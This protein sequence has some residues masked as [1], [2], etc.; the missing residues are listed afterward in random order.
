MTD[1]QFFVHSHLLQIGV[2]IE[3]NRSL[4]RV[5]RQQLLTS[6]IYTGNFQ[7]QDFDHLILVTGRLPDKF[8]YEDLRARISELEDVGI[9]SLQRIGD[10]LVPSSIADAVYR[11]HRLAREADTLVSTHAPRELP[12]STFED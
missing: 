6:C 1:E 11:G 4:A 9:T 2:E 12:V 10:C 8:L 3:C 5:D 7:T